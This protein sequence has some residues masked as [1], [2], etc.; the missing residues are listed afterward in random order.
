VHC[1]LFGAHRDD[2]DDAEEAKSNQQDIAAS[3]A[4]C[5]MRRCTAASWG[6][7]PRKAIDNHQGAPT[8]EPG[9]DRLRVLR[10]DG[11]GD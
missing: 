6:R 10:C 4:A 3:S 7:R 1:V 2:R 9:P 5:L 11:Q 8:T